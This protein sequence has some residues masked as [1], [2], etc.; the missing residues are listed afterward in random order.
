[1]RS[2]S[3]ND[4]WHLLTVLWLFIALPTGCNAV[5]PLR[6]DQGVGDQ[7]VIDQAN[8]ESDAARRFD[9][10]GGEGTMWDSS[11]TDGT[12]TARDSASLPRDGGPLPDT[13]LLTFCSG[14]QP[15]ILYDGVA[16]NRF[17]TEVGAQVQDHN[18]GYGEDV[19]FFGTRPGD[20][21]TSGMRVDFL[22]RIN[23]PF[24]PSPIDLGKQHANWK[25]RVG[26][27]PNC[28]NSLELPVV[29]FRGT[30]AFELKTGDPVGM[31][32]YLCM[33][34]FNEKGAAVAPFSH[35]QLYLPARTMMPRT[36]IWG[37]DQTCNSDRTL[38]A[39]IG[40][41]DQF[42]SC[43]CPNGKDAMTTRCL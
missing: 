18:Y 9:G 15:K 43:S 10:A 7:R 11:T 34:I 30:Y 37:F 5:H 33:E 40:T 28:P 16:P 42:G 23:Q 21:H 4:R 1:M 27:S 24:P 31:A 35:V 22:R 14:G 25:V 20:T 39:P 8:H 19:G 41:C 3:D 36:C 2:A 12:S 17:H 38:T 26:C 13:N 32:I 29:R 6:G